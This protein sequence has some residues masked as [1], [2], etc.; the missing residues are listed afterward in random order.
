MT[1]TPLEMLNACL[2]NLEF[3]YQIAKKRESAAAENGHHYAA[4]DAGG[5]ASAFSQSIALLRS[6]FATLLDAQE[7][8]L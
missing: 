3:A 5:A 7:G 8:K 6:E 1:R 4:L 2:A